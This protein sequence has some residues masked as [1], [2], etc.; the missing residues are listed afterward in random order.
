M[1]RR[2]LFV[3]G[4][5]TLLVG[6]ASAAW[7]AFDS[8]EGEPPFG[9]DFSGN[10]GPGYEG[11]V[12]MIFDGYDDL[13]LTAA[14][15]S[16]VARLRK[17]AELHVFYERYACATAD[18]CGLCDLP[19]PR[20]SVTDSGPI[21]LCLEGQIEA[22]VVSDFGLG[23]VDIRLRN[24]SGFVS[25]IDPDDASVRAVAADIDVTAK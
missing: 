22:E 2:K 1:M 3:A 25:E 24:M 19:G 16:A 14:G 11:I 9:I 21:A 17:G 20:L 10:P 8:P 12:T 18:P 23:A 5:A 4:I 13:D 7:G 15:F 6:L